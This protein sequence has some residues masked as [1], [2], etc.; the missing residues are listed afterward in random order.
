MWRVS[1]PFGFPHV[2]NV[3]ALSICIV[4]RAFVVVIYMCLLYVSLGSRVIP[5]MFGLI[6]K[7]SVLLLICSA[8]KNSQSETDYIP[9]IYIYIYSAGSGVK[10]TACCF[11]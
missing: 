1:F 4:L 8:K 2:V 5:S 3:S 10:N 9:I 11:V 6:F 7:G